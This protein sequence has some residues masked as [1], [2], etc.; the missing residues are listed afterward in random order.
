M[1][2]IIKTGT[3]YFLQKQT[4]FGHWN[5]D[6]AVENIQRC[7]HKLPR[8]RKILIDALVVCRYWLE[9]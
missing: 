2:A 1:V 4:G 6:T 8:S 7:N 3:R 5:T 9:M